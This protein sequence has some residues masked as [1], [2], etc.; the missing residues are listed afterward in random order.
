MVLASSLTIPVGRV[1]AGLLGPI[2]GNLAG[3][4]GRL[5][6][7]IVSACDPTR[8]KKRNLNLPDKSARDLCHLN[9]EENDLMRGP[10]RVLD[11]RN[12]N[13]YGI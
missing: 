8:P 4:S 6:D 13:H 9:V 10:V 2:P 11:T 12:G 1:P 5:L 7:G 3:L